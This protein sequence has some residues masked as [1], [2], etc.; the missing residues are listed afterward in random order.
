MTPIDCGAE[1]RHH[2]DAV[3]QVEPEGRATANELVPR[4]ERPRGDQGKRHTDTLLGARAAKVQDA[5]GR[6]GTE[7]S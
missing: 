2:R 4:P 7:K 1:L 5:G 3:A 6:E